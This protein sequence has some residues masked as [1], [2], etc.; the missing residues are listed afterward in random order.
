MWWLACGRGAEQ[1]RGQELSAD[2]LEQLGAQLTEYRL[3]K[4]TH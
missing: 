4:A 3:E 1:L 2:Q